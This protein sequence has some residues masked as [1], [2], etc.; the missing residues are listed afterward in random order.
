M[1]HHI[2][3]N[4]RLYNVSINRNFYQNRFIN[5]CTRK[6]KVL[7]NYTYASCMQNQMYMYQILQNYI[8]HII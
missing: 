4:L 8:D 6:K 1:I 3:K 5:E 2:K 7:N